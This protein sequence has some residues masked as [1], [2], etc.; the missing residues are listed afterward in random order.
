[1]KALT[2]DKVLRKTFEHLDAVLDEKNRQIQKG[3]KASQG[4][5]PSSKNCRQGR[6]KVEGRVA[7][8][9]S[10]SDND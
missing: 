6:R 1:M 3:S 10:N 7:T 8:T 4:P 2:A 9:V 5:A